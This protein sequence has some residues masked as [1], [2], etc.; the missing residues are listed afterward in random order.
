MTKKFAA[1]LAIDTLLAGCAS[2]SGN[3]PEIYRG[4]GDYKAVGACMFD[5][6]DHHYTA[7]LQ[8]VDVSTAQRVIIR[9]E[10]PS[11]GIASHTLRDLDIAVSQSGP[12]QVTIE[13][14]RWHNLDLLNFAGDIR[15]ALQACLPDGGQ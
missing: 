2:V 14:R 5:R 4:R 3:A 15:A 1:V 13:V 12:D 9:H 11:G 6:L 10:G 8:L 7:G